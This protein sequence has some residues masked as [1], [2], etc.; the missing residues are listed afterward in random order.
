GNTVPD[1]YDW[2]LYGPNVSCGSLGEPIRCSTATTQ[3]QTNN[4]G[5]MGNTGI[6]TASNNL[7]PGYSCASTN[8]FNETSCGNGWVND[9]AVTTGQIYYLC[10]SKWSAGGS[11]FNL[12][13]TLTGGAGIDCTILPIE[14]TSFECHPQ[15]NVITIDW[16]TASELNNDHFLLEKSY[17]GEHY[18]TLATVPGKAF[19]SLPS[20]YF[21]L[22]N[23]PYPGNNYY[24]L[25][26]TDKNGHAQQ[27][28][29]TVC[30]VT[31][32]DEQVLMQVMNLSGHVLYAA[33]L[34]NS[35]VEN[36][37]HDLSL[38]AGMYITAIIYKNGMATISKF[39][40]TE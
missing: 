22:D 11:G 12:N 13:W 21:M 14:L 1:D 26:Q 37:L 18:E 4:T 7:Y 2:A 8:D 36:I 6:G 40:K 32:S 29:T 9:L 15:G 24:R 19:S 39:L 31:I 35:E 16:T 33:N 30:D 34:K 3:N 28:K 5:S 17:D 10:V 20:N 25:S 38:P 27:L 23:H